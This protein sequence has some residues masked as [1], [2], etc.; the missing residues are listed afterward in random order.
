VTDDYLKLNEA[1][2]AQ[3][4][5]AEIIVEMGA[6]DLAALTSDQLQRLATAAHNLAQA[7]WEARRMHRS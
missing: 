7:A 2:E 5:A 3:L 1:Q 6:I 4:L